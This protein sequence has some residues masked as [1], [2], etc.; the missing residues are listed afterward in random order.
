M[1]FP[2][3]DD[4]SSL[5]SKPIITYGLIGLNA[6]IFLSEIFGAFDPIRN[7]GIVPADFFLHTL[8]YQNFFWTLFL[9]GGWS[10]L[11]FNMLFLYV[12]GDNVEDNFGKVKFIIFYFIAG[13]CGSLAHVYF[14]QTSQAPL[15]GASGAISGILG[16][17]IF[18]FPN[19]QIKVFVVGFLFTVRAWIALGIWIALQFFL[20]V[21]EYAQNA[22]A[23]EG[24]A[25]IAHIGGFISGV[26]LVIL[27]RRKKSGEVK[28][29]P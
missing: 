12:F 25:H 6:V 23:G 17:Y 16:A 5:R 21:S 22:G 18:L 29:L 3:G 11:V 24:V 7:Y 4:N 27:F 26:A 8:P 15:I 9:H 10:H 28:V 20:G 2:L 14:N 19:N 1:L 13:I